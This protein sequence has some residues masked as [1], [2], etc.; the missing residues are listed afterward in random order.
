LFRKRKDI[1][2]DDKLH[3]LNKKKDPTWAAPLSGREP[4]L[5]ERER[6]LPGG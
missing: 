4:E 2:K 5:K 6:L 3:S 1:T